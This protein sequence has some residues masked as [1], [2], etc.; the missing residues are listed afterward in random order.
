MKNLYA[1]TIILFF[2][3]SAFG[4]IPNGNFESWTTEFNYE[5]PTSWET[6]QDTVYHRLSKDTDRIEGEYSLK[7]STDSPS[8]W[9]DCNS[10]AR[11]STKL[12]QTISENQYINFYL[13]SIPVDSQDV[14][15]HFRAN[16]FNDGL[17]VGEE[18]FQAQQTYND[19]ALIEFAD[20]PIG[21]DSLQIIIAS[22]AIN[23]ADDG[24]YQYTSSWVD[25]LGIKKRTTAT[26]DINQ[27]GVSIFPNPSNGIF[28]IQQN[29][30][31]Y[32]RY[33]IVDILGREI[34]SGNINNASVRITRSGPYI[35][36]LYSEVNSNRDIVRR[37]LVF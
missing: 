17:N 11:L 20:I 32:K 29:A 18:S 26:K 30:D 5:R 31:E 3:Q 13:K 28:N 14:F 24:C 1:L 8:G 23:G 34:K 9:V 2:G 6:N 10:I 35:L 37:I 22:G 19:F 33:R 16:Y 12:D 21:V 7:L 25:D 4:Q 15:F 36:Q 27:N